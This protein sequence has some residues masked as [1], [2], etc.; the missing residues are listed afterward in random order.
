[1]KFPE[2]FRNK[3]YHR[4]QE[5]N[6]LVKFSFLSTLLPSSPLLLLVSSSTEEE[7]RN[8][9]WLRS[10]SKGIW[11]SSDN[12][13]R[14]S[15]ERLGEINSRGGEVEFGRSN[16]QSDRDS[17]FKVDESE[18]IPLGGERSGENE[19]RGEVCARR[20][21]LEDMGRGGLRLIIR[22]WSCAL[23]RK[24]STPSRVS[25]GSWS[26]VVA[27]NCQSNIQA[28]CLTVA[29]KK[30]RGR[31]GANRHSRVRRFTPTFS[32]SV[33]WRGEEGEGEERGGGRGGAS[34]YTK[35]IRRWRQLPKKVDDRDRFE[36]GQSPMRV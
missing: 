7:I 33:E 8:S 1:M 2:K 17:D 27:W 3:A 11:K 14:E 10:R 35:G 18:I 32:D 30:N 5:I 19:H 16:E 21:A 9:L 13:R 6:S 34:V 4:R 22:G 23:A 20:C 26:F 29:I 31:A 36:F 28:A 25:L 12:A 24:P 15:G